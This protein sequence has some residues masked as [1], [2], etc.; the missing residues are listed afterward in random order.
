[1]ARKMG[2]AHISKRSRSVSRIVL[3]SGVLVMSSLAGALLVARCSLRDA[4]FGRSVILLLQH[5]KEGAFGL[6]LN[7]PSVTKELPFPIYVGGPCKLQGLLMLHGHEDWVEDEEKQEG[8]ICP[9]V[10]LGDSG[11][12]DRLHDMTPASSWRFR[13]F[14]GYSGW[15]PKQ[16][17]AELA[18]DAWLVLP[19][20]G[21]RVFDI[22]NEELWPTLA[23]P[24]IPEPSMN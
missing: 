11:C 7:K 17:E 16:L 3:V 10:F 8:L 1:M 19:A 12:F 9:G 24:T 20:H 6:V 15:G 23:P 13:V 18:E 2:K 5:G 21:E 14:S 4:L 22:P